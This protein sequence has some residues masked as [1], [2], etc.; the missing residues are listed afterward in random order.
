MNV[1]ASGNHPMKKD[2]IGNLRFLV[3]LLALLALAGCGSFYDAEEIP[4][5]VLQKEAIWPDP[6]I[7]DQVCPAV[8]MGLVS[9]QPLPPIESRGSCGHPAPFSVVA[10]G[11]DN[12]VQFNTDATI[13]CV[14]TSQLQ[15]YFSESVQPL[16]LQKLGQPVVEI[17]IA[18]S[19]SCR[20]RNNQRGAK[21]SEHGRA[22]AIDIGAFKLADGTVLTV[23]KDWPR[24]G[25]AGRF[26]R[27]INRSA[28]RYFTTVIGPGGDKYHQDHIHLDHGEHGKSGTWRVCQ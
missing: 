13:N 1:A 26:L 18:A 7:S 21:L 15:R 2:R 16:A 5:E 25:R 12:P 22:N 27:A 23:K 8:V 6:A 24:S 14:V 19:Y 20:P 11:G 9:A 10:L 3:S 4:Q 17:Q 28:C